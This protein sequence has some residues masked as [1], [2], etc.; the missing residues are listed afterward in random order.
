[1]QIQTHRRLGMVKRIG[2][3]EVLIIEGVDLFD[4]F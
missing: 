4:F 1:M 2:S 3:W